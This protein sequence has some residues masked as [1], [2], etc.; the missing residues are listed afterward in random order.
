MVILLELERKHY[1][2]LACMYESGFGGYSFR[3]M[4]GYSKTGAIKDLRNRGVICPRY[5]YRKG[6]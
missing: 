5:T 4:I 6:I 3:K 2:F 1:G